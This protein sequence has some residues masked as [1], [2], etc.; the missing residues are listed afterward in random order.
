MAY[1]P[2]RGLGLT[3]TNNPLRLKGLFG[4]R[5]GAFKLAERK[6]LG[7]FQAEFV[8]APPTTITI[9]DNTGATYAGCLATMAKENAAT[10]N[11]S[12]SATFEAV[13]YFGGDRTHGFILPTGLSS[14]GAG[15]VTNAKI[16]V[17]VTEAVC[18]GVSVTQNI[19][20]YIL[21]RNQVQSQ[22]TWNNY[23]TGNA[24]TTGGGLGASDANL[25]AIATIGVPDGT[26]NTY[27]EFTGAAVDQYF[28]DVI[29]GVIPNY[30]ILLARDP[31]TAYDTAY[32]VFNSD[33][34]TDGFRPSYEFD[35]VAG[36]GGVTGVGTS[37][38][39]QTSSASGSFTP[40]NVTGA[41]ASSQAQTSVAT[42]T[43][44]PAAVTGTATT[45]QAQTSNA[46]GV[47]SAGV[48]GNATSS[49]AQSSTATGAHTVAN[50][51]GTGTNSQAQTSAAT[52]THSPANVTATGASSQAQT[53]IAT[54][55][56]STGV[57][58]I[59]SSS[60][61]QTSAASGTHTVAAVTGV[62]T[63]AQ[64]QTS[65]ATG[66]YAPQA[67]TGNATS[68]QAQTSN[69]NGLFSDGVL[70][71]GTSSQAQTSNAV[72]VCTNPDGVI[73]GGLSRQH[74]ATLPRKKRVIRE[75][76]ELEEVELNERDAEIKALLEVVKSKKT[77]KSRQA[78]AKLA[79]PMLELP[80]VELISTKKT[81]KIDVS[82]YVPISD[83]EI[84]LLLALMM[85]M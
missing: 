72:G 55:V 52:G 8:G 5:N 37:S 27:F 66:T 39:A 14:V 6:A 46:T 57:S 74:I 69:A 36:G 61:A 64:T 49:Q 83:D 75:D 18:Q 73:S 81:K 32:V 30:G 63:S 26:T 1:K 45:S 71:A 35:W 53:S 13:S 16:R 59:G 7:Y 40:A 80:K 70:G 12:S 23:S 11:Y 85:E 48:T 54:G 17:R 4:N 44:T 20:A 15:T 65:N 28:E 41:G 19:S 77:R 76:D 79:L 60:Q 22:L 56:F 24:F 10:T 25:T 42:G 2:K 58:G 78:E 62:G 47:F 68:S 67:V 33:N 29:N 9:S 51:S 50:V 31:D 21:S 38:Q 3:P 43:H 82:Q 84:E 34:A